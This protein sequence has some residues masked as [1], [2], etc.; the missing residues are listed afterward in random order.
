MFDFIANLY[1]QAIYRPILNLLVWLYVAIPPQ[2]IGVAII[3]VTIIIRTILAPFMNKSLRGQ[4]ALSALQPKMNEL[5]E[6]HKEDR[7]AQA[8]A[9]MDLYREH[10][11]NPLSSCLPVL[12]QLPVLLALFHVFRRALNGNLEGLYSFVPNPGV[13]DPYFFGIVDLSHPN[14]IF[15]I[16]AGVAQYWQS[17]MI[18]R[19][20]GTNRNN[21][22]TTK[23]MNAQMTYILP[24]ISVFVAWKLPAGL[25]LYWI[26]TTLF[27]VAQQYY[28][29]RTYKPTVPATTTTTN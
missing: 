3:A 4:R 7:E 12:I 22:T 21:D 28:I 17:R 29:Q 11:V 1:N 2:D 8:K 14:A 26:V 18:I 25:P 10:K 13:I 5:R 19:W 20:Q 27:A 16:L 15:A 9:M 24:I 23:M 6:T